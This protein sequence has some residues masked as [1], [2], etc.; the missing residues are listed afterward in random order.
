[1]SVGQSSFTRRDRVWQDE[2]YVIKTIKASSSNTRIFN[3]T[4]ATSIILD[5]DECSEGTHSCDGNATCNDTD[6]SYECVCNTG[7]TGDGFSCSSICFF[8]TGV[9][10]YSIT[11]ILLSDID[12]CSTGSVCH[13]NAECMDTPGSYECTCFSGYTGDGHTCQDIDECPTDPCHENATCTNNNGSFSCDCD[14][15]FLGNGIFCAGMI[16]ILL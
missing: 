7:Y 11:D 10:F 5:I 9:C 12:E 15:G 1:M 14:T 3:V 13:E 4:F 8:L 6:S 16:V 2:A